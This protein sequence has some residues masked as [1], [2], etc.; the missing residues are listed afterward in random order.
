MPF[1]NNFSPLDYCINISF[2]REKWKVQ[3]C[4]S[5]VKHEEF[6]FKRKI[7]EVLLIK[8]KIHM[9]YLAF[10]HVLFFRIKMS[11]VLNREY[12]HVV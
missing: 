5:Y 6:F 8:K 10:F 9:K 1:T 3:F 12:M 2:Y 7:S 4:H 11:L